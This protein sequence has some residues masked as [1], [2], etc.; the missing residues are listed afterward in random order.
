MNFDELVERYEEAKQRGQ[1]IQRVQ[2][3]RG[4]RYI[5]EFGMEHRRGPFTI[6]GRAAYKLVLAEMPCASHPSSVGFPWE[7]CAIC[8]NST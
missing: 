2:V 5:D 1:L 4:R 6:K 8:E 7:A 3:P